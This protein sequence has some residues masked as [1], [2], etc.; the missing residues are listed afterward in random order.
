[1]EAVARELIRRDITAEVAGTCA[2]GDEVSD[3]LP[4]ALLRSSHTDGL[5]P[6]CFAEDPA[7]SDQSNE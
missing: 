2:L 1:M 3:E 6:A 4:E 7:S 5:C